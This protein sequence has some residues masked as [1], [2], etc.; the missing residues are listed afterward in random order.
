ME[1]L[2]GYLRLADFD[3]LELSNLNRLPATILDQGLNKA[4]IAARR[5]AEL[6]PYLQVDVD[7]RGVLQ[8]SAAEFVDSLDIVVDE[9]D[10]LDIKVELRLAARERGIPVVMATSDRGLIDVERFDLDPGLEVFHGLLGKVD[11]TALQGLSTRDKAPFVMRILEA[12][13][14]SSRLAASLVETDRT[15]SSWPQL[16]SEVTLGAASVATAVR[17]I[18]RGEAVPSGRTRI[19]L[20]RA[21]AALHP[22]ALDDEPF[23]TDWPPAPDP[24]PAGVTSALDAMVD[25][26]RLAP[27]GGNSQPWTITQYPGRIEITEQTGRTTAMDVGFRGTHVAIGAATFNARVAAARF[28]VGGP[29]SI[30]TDPATGHPTVSIHLG[31][32]TDDVLADYYEAMIDRMSN[33][34]VGVRRPLDSGTLRALH[35]AVAAEGGRL[36][37]TTDTDQ[38]AELGDLLAASDRLRYLTPT[39]HQQMISELNWPG[40][41][42]LDRGI[43]I[44]TLALDATDTVKLEV[45]ARPDVMARLAEWGV[46]TAL[47]D[48]AR[49]R[50]RDASGLA[51]VTVR[52][53]SAADYVTGGMALEHLWVLTTRFGLGV[54][55][56]S[57]VFIYA[58]TDNDLATLTPHC[59]EELRELRDRFTRILGIDTVEA[60]ILVLRITHQPGV[61]VRSGR[62]SRRAN[63]LAKLG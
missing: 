50:I 7:T 29:T 10:S 32:S 28:G 49:D 20:D 5:I 46:G 1:G 33:R 41:D 22:P 27:S 3:L 42:P 51:V 9:C 44:R 34:T 31:G 26:I 8:N 61:A 24:R 53:D 18:I 12:S 48:H 23:G 60:M 4:V 16:A 56:I 58:R 13:E 47:G 35:D 45:S 39:L 52:G 40:R 43:D 54:Y 17:R 21:L 59:V 25:A 55:P 11:P 15:V 38:L 2:C 63:V 36:V 57:P 6:D 37:V 30:A 62:L 14:L 19:D